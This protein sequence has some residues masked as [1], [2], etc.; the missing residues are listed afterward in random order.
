MSSCP[1]INMPEWKSLEKSV[2]TFEA[3][4]DFMETDGMIRTPEKVQAKISAKTKLQ[5][6]RIADDVNAVSYETVKSLTKR[7]AEKFGDYEYRLEELPNERYKGKV[8]LVDG[9]RV[10]VINTATATLDTPLHEFGHI[11]IDL[12][13][14]GNSNLLGNLIKDI[15]TNHKDVLDEIYETYSDEEAYANLSPE[16]FHEIAVEEAIVEL[17][18][19]LA[20]GKINPDTG[21]YNKLMKVWE[22]IISK[23]KQLFGPNQDI[24]DVIYIPPSLSLGDLSELLASNAKI[25][26]GSY[27]KGKASSDKIPGLKR[28]VD[29]MNVYLSDPKLEDNYQK[30]LDRESN[31]IIVVDKNNFFIAQDFRGGSSARPG[32][33]DGTLGNMTAYVADGDMMRDIDTFYQELKSEEYTSWETEEALRVKY[34]DLFQ[35][36]ML[37]TVA[38]AYSDSPIKRKLEKMLDV[39]RNTTRNSYQREDRLGRLSMELM[40]E[41]RQTGDAFSERTKQYKFSPGVF[42][43]D[44]FT[45]NFGLQDIMVDGYKFDR[46]L[47]MGTKISITSDQRTLSLRDLIEKEKAKIEVQIDNLEVNSLQAFDENSQTTKEIKE[48]TI[49]IETL[50]PK[51]GEVVQEKIY[52]QAGTER[53]EFAENPYVGTQIG[54]VGF[55]SNIF[56]Y[57]DAYSL[58]ELSDKRYT[59]EDLYWADYTVMFT[60]DLKGK[61]GNYKLFKETDTHYELRIENTGANETEIKRNI[62]G[63][64]FETRTLKVSDGLGQGG[65]IAEKAYL[66]IV[67]KASKS[68][69]KIATSINRRA[70]PIMREVMQAITELNYF[71]EADS[72][73]FSPIERSVAGG[74]KGVI[75][76]SGLYNIFAKKTY[77]KYHRV[78][79]KTGNIITYAELEKMFDALTPE[80]KEKARLKINR[81][82]R[83][84]DRKI[85][86][87][88][89]DINAFQYDVTEATRVLIPR[90][91]KSTFMSPTPNVPLY[92]LKRK[93]GNKQMSEN[94]SLAEIAETTQGRSED[95]TITSDQLK[96]TKAIEVANKMSEMLGI[97]YE[98]V[99]ATDA[100]EITKDSKNPWN[101]EA[102]FFYGGKIYFIADRMNTE[103]AFHEFA[104]PIIRHIAQTNPK[105]L[106]ALFDEL[107][108]TT[109]GQAI[110]QSVAENYP[111]LE[112]DSPRFKEEAI[113]K[114]LAS[115]ANN[116]LSNEKTPSAFAKFIK[117]LLY[118]IKQTLRKTFGRAIP[119]SKLD[120][121]TTLDELSDILVKGEKIEI[122]TEVL[123]DEELVAYSREAYGEVSSD[124]EKIGE[125]DIQNTV[126]TFYDMI[127]SQLNMLMRNEN[128]E[129]LAELLTDEYQRGDLQAMKGNL[130]QWQTAVAKMADEFREDVDESKNRV[131]AL[132]NT[133]FRLESVMEKVFA[134]IQDISKYPDT[135]DNMHKA[136][137]YDKF[138]N[139]W[140]SFIEEFK[141]VI[142]KAE[143]GVPNRSPLVALTEDTMRNLR[144]SKE[145][146]NEM[147]AAGA[148]D[149]V[150]EQLEPINRSVRERYEG[151]IAKLRE[152]GAPQERIDV[153]FKEYHGMTEKEYTQMNDM[154]ARD[155]K[156]NLSIGEKKNLDGLLA[157]SQKGLSINKDKIEAL[158][159]GNMGDA[160]WFNSYLE[161]YLYNTDPIVGG[162]A[163]YTKNALN[164]VMIVSQEKFN[165]FAETMRPLLETAGYNPNKLGELGEKIGF[166]DKVAK[167]DR[168][169]GELEEKEVWSFINRFKNYRYDEDSLAHA[170]T[171]AQK[172]YS[173]EN[174]DANKQVLIDA[175]AAQKEWQRKYMNQEYVSEFYDR[176]SIFEKDA[177]GKKAAYL[178]EE[179]FERMR[180]ITEPAKTQSDQMLIA[181]E[182]DD[183]WRE[184]R[185]M[186]SRYDLNGKL[187]TGETAEIAKRLRDFR[188]QSRDFYEW[189]IRKGVFEN[190]YIDFTQELKNEGVDDAEYEVRINE[191]KK[192]NSRKVI[193][194][195]WYEKRNLILNRVK[196]L[197]SK[198]PDSERKNVDQGAI[199]EKIIE[200]TGGYRDDDNQIIGTDLSEGSQQ[201]I[202]ELE[203]Q[204]AEMKKEGVKNNGLTQIETDR[205]Y[206][207]L[208]KK[209]SAGRLGSEDYK[210]LQRLYDLKNDRGLSEFEIAELNGLYAELSQLS[211]REATPYYVDILNNWLSKLNTDKIYDKW[212]IRN[213][214][215]ENV[216]NVMT[217]EVVK[218]L[219]NQDAE[220]AKWFNTAHLEE[221]YSEKV[222]GS[223]QRIKKTRYK[224]T[225]PWSIIKPSDPT[226]MES[227]QIKNASGRVID[228][229]E[230]LPSMDYYARVVKSK[231]KTRRVMNETVDN[232][233]RFLP[234][235][236]QPAGS[237]YINEKYEAM[238]TDD[239]ALFAVLE[240]MKEFHLKHQDGLSY[241]S[242]LYLDFPRFQK[243]GLEILQSTKINEAGQK[244][245]N[246]L[247]Q[248]AQRVKEFFT[249]EKSQSEDGYSYNE[250]FNLVR[251]DMFDN[252]T[253]DIP[254]AGLFDLEAN[255]VTTNVTQSMM[256][257]MMSAERQKQLVKISPIVR[258]IQNTLNNPVNAINDLNKVNEAEFKNRG[259]L[260]YLPKKD[261]VRL[262]AV[263]NLIEREFEGIAQKGITADVPWLNNFANLLFK[264]ASFS[265]FALNIPSALK[266]SLGMKFQEMIEAS[267]GQYVDHTSLQKGNAWS[268]KAMA[269]L[270]FTGELYKKG[271]KS[272]MQQLVDSF[273][274]IQGKFEEKFGENMSRTMLKD[275][276]E[277]SWLYSPRKWVEN[278]AGIQLGAGMLYKKKVTRLLDDGSTEEIPYIEAFETVDNQIRLKDGIDIRYALNPTKIRVKEGDSYAS[279]AKRY[280]I[281]ESEIENVFGR[282]PIENVL[283]NVDDIEQDR[284]DELADI[285]D[286]STITDP[287]EKIKLQDRIDAINRKYDKK[288]DTAGRNGGSVEIQNS[289]FK[290]MK[291]RMQQVANNMG[292][293]YA[294]FDQP[295]AQR[296]LA[297]RFISYLRRYFTTMATNR[298][299]FS[300]SLWDAKPRLNPGLGDVQMGFYIQFSKTVIETIKTGGKN[301]PYMTAP[302]KAA[303]L[304]FF[305]EVAMLMVTTMLMSVIFGFDPEDDERFSKLRAKSGALPFPLT[306]SDPDRE[307]D[308]LSYMELHSLHMLMQVR[309]ENEQF[310]LFTGG[311]KQYNSLLDIKSVA[312]GPTTD[313]YV[314]LY[315]DTK[316]IATGDPS[317]YYSRNVGPYQ[318]QDKGGSKFMTHL[319]KTVGLTGSTLD[320]AL[321]IQNFQTYQTKVRR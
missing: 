192:R 249:G 168:E 288:L 165:V 158:L 78:R 164:D 156:G 122:N 245:W 162:L 42:Y 109:E 210:E 244:K 246:A 177:I 278:Q 6:R 257:Y 120:A 135:Q 259:I 218:D 7:M 52:I 104:H 264:R 110:I 36:A 81:S 229:I 149:A 62:P 48:K 283:E 44:V 251:A 189:K 268:Y 313:S 95:N 147:Y 55:K 220:F 24:I 27:V 46:N 237:T 12:I 312:F 184:Y 92:Q 111:E 116:K 255:E 137:H 157:L 43:A 126:N 254:I 263:N 49:F 239:P 69:M 72:I 113:V 130:G 54:E 233:G 204:L 306:S 148:R 225:Y 51:T 256:R 238:R 248:Y 282:V 56:N 136:Y 208:K 173:S 253:T 50:N 223:N 293:A 272:H 77:G 114:A 30:I 292:G 14:K 287:F 207:L 301:L 285:D 224:R 8:E 138:I 18:G 271:A 180:S 258:A 127:S 128:Y 299:G 20:A 216:D 121:A 270:S 68:K 201:E 34:S 269:E 131:E 151:M 5:L 188:K 26:I 64:K 232:R 203:E 163:L 125:K 74:P 260:S 261:N 79:M 178:R 297:F 91:F 290:F 222:E 212:K 98:M 197:V 226:M 174:N 230:G 300:G 176:Q 262:T 265:F 21:L 124:L 191:W 185:N 155:K 16:E 80:Q 318:W 194:D 115:D 71:K 11:F 279:I 60:F 166:T 25:T 281:P 317:A 75:N 85:R 199:W 103:M 108:S 316:A 17:L 142:D 214:T 289:E 321:A 276:A 4:R 123:S 93:D 107:N 73:F 31:Q 209:K 200:L 28:E 181:D 38:D 106:D 252:E 286:I 179:F 315:E 144:K 250:Q 9:K 152:Q 119:V 39:V 305:T 87:K 241:K 304:K 240:K 99:S 298:W 58:K 175:V 83:I 2:G 196:E 170:V 32:S 22:A 19:R 294:K 182:V 10:I 195:E 88:E 221:E 117:D 219:I 66:I 243:E 211:Q 172:Q 231:Y 228:T 102:A 65:Q 82:N 167:W 314:Q 63:V 311:I 15:E 154:I 57:S 47:E 206:A 132:S 215:A 29:A 129:E 169:T 41:A 187:K 61:P 94:P 101:G 150:F 3:Y 53:A 319:A 161:G 202:K 291:N 140:T 159:R 236:I 97:D 308:G 67:P 37:K 310:N 100:A 13:R 275:T 105:Q 160:N 86:L 112:V 284:R 274:M 190:A 33:L 295:E 247:S 134:H 153:I 309:G 273:D 45:N 141:A 303:A 70:I 267:G 133:L 320:P 139:H 143:N 145:L 213:V 227:Y 146:I 84:G 217:E 89:Y 266:N 302:E 296:Y 23:I 40:S 35:A 242:R 118:A 76:R 59:I 307:F 277:I 186:H 1:N 183:L 193:K 280:N 90:N 234:K 171:E 235:A 205:F 96:N 198:L